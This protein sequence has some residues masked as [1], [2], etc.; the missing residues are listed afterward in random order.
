VHNV[1]SEFRC[2]QLADEAGLG[3]ERLWPPVGVEAG[4]ARGASTPDMTRRRR[5]HH[6]GSNLPL[7]E[8]RFELS[9]T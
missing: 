3:V 5:R 2:T 1:F 4:C 6:N 9:I 8:S 7:V